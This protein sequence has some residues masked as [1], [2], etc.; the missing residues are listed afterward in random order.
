VGDKERLP[1]IENTIEA[2]T[3]V[4]MVSRVLPDGIGAARVSALRIPNS[5]SDERPL[6]V[7]RVEWKSVWPARPAFTAD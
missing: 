5:S 7:I 2:R 4:L 1:S 3:G 6:D